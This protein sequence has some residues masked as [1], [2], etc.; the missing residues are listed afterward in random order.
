[1]P[2]KFKPSQTVRD[3]SGKTKTE[4]FY[5]KSTLVSELTE[6]LENK[7]TQPK[8][9]QKIRNELAKRGHKC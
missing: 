5:M 7:N 9:R 2:L 1:M 6:A 4:H 3:K 8:R